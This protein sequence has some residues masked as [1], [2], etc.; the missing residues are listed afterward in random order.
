M[1][2][3]YTFDIETDPF[4]YGRLPRAFAC[5]LYDGRTTVS[6]WGPD[7]CAKMRQHL[8][9]IPAGLIY[10]HNGGKFDIY[11]CMDWIVGN[12]MRVINR[13]IVEA[14]IQCA[15]GNRHRLR[16]SWAIMP[17]SLARLTKGGAT[18]KQD[19]DW[20]K[21]EAEVR[22]ENKAEILDYLSMDV[23]SLWDRVTAFLERFGDYLTVGSMAMS[24]L[25]KRHEFESLTKPVNDGIRGSYYY[26]ARVECLEKG[27][28]KDDFR[29]Y[30]V[31]SMYPFVM[32]NFAH[33]IGTVMRYGETI[34]SNTRFLK[35]RGRVTTKIL[36]FLPYAY[37][38]VT[39]S[40][41]ITIHEFIA[42]EECELF[43]CLEVVETL[44]IFE[45][46][47][48]GAFVD[49][50]YYEKIKCQ[51]AGDDIGEKLAKFALNSAYGKF[52]QDSA[53]YADWLI[54]DGTYDCR[55]GGWEKAVGYKGDNQTFDYV[56]WQRPSERETV[57]NSAVGASITGAAR[58]VL[59]RA[60]AAADRPIY[61]D[62]DSIACRAL[63]QDV[64]PDKTTLGG[65]K[66]EAE[67]DEACI[68]GKK[69][70]AFFQKNKRVKSANKGVRDVTD[71][72]FRR[73][74]N[75][76]VITK[77]NN[78]PTYMLDGTAK[79]ISRDIRMT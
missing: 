3:V 71:D 30:D 48:F 74:A 15:N 16:D 25:R 4:A 65:W 52:A 58:S 53:K 35:V 9:Y 7:C 12:P 38:P 72:E 33:P 76:E 6:F 34:T 73:I 21:L 46:A 42:A 59:L 19:I 45:D 20:Q 54:T 62:T 47:T 2:P 17:L 49:D 67:A 8:E 27:H 28:L 36:P 31:N 63:S 78:A 43:K 41:A 1:R 18:E 26:G 75:G 56:M 13:R 37:D 66:L 55:A 29:I 14:E 61:C 22:D 77:R 23:V 79:F 60:L 44:D 24:E 70:Y 68:S 10:Y 69:T 5:A 57:Y 11:H 64:V 40:Y 51:A 50:F 39:N 32:R